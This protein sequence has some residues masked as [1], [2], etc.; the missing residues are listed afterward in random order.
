MTSEQKLKRAFLEVLSL[1][2]NDI[3]DELAYNTVP[4]WDSVGHMQ[5]IAA[6]EDGF[7]IMLDTEDIIGLSTYAKG[8]EILK[9]YGAQF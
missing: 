7:D 2:E 1:N 5:L 8:R 6:L 9:K 3:T 4:A